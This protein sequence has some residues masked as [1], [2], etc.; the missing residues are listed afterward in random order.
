[1]QTDL[2]SSEYRFP[3]I[4]EVFAFR[5]LFNQRFTNNQIAYQQLFLMSDA[6]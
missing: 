3:C 4:D 6:V 1:M 2:R 5:H